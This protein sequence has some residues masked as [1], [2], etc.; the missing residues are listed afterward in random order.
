MT[1]SF[2]LEKSGSHGCPEL[3]YPLLVNDECVGCFDLLKDAAAEA[4]KMGAVAIDSFDYT[5]PDD[6]SSRHALAL[7]PDGTWCHTFSNMS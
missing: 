1:T 4:R 3:K 7:K 6:E 2:R 5:L